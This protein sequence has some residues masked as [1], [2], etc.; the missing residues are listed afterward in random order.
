MQ[1]AR[2]SSCSLLSRHWPVFFSCLGLGLVLF[3]CLFSLAANAD[4]PPCKP[5]ALYGLNFSPYPGDQHPGRDPS[6]NRTLLEQRLALVSQCTGHI[7][8]FSVRH[9][10]DLTADL[11]PTFGLRITPAAWL[12]RDHE[13][14]LEAIRTLVAVA[15]RHPDNIDAIIIGSENLLR[16]ELSVKQLQ[17]YLRHARSELAGLK[18][19][20]GYADSHD[21]LKRHPQIISE[22]DIVFANFYPYWE[23]YAIDDSL[24]AVQRAW[25]ELLAITGDKPVAISETGWP[26]C[27]NAVGKAIPSPE[28]SARYLREFRQWAQREHVR[29][30]YFSA[31]D[32]SWKAEHE[33]PQGACWGLFDENGALKKG[34]TEALNGAATNTRPIHL[35]PADH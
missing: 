5:D 14:N 35:Q 15:R 30:F 4:S 3:L 10:A 34:M 20:V 22:V 9:G 7:R 12:S 16:Q 1:Q 17:A 28:N 18:V 27:G 29:Y 13:G 24:P 19:K 11:A 33:G 8:T 21:M 23:G 26:S 6:I 2:T 25:Q 31:F 32:A